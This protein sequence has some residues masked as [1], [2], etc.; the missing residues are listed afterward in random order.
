VR[1]LLNIVPDIVMGII[2]LGAMLCV[3]LILI[4]WDTPP[5]AI[6]TFRENRAAFADVVA[7][8]ED[9]SR[10]QLQSDYLITQ[11]LFDLGIRHLRVEAT[12]I[13]FYF[14]TGP[15]T[16]SDRILYLPNGREED[17]PPYGRPFVRIDD[18]WY[19]VQTD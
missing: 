4:H 5:N 12:H 9:K 8:I 19:Y 18:N 16:P 7:R 10:P 2:G 3:T 11:A 13:V 15:I 6:R 14:A 1:R 17:L